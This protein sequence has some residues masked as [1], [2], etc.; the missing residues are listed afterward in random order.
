MNRRGFLGACLAAGVAP[1]VVRSGVLMPVKAPVIQL[2]TVYEI[3]AVSGST[4]RGAL[5]GLDMQQWINAEKQLRTLTIQG[6]DFKIGD[7]ITFSP[8]A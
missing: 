5:N 1:W 3:T 4:S 7:R 6:H 2:P 8:R